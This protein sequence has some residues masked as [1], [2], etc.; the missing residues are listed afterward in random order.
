MSTQNIETRET[1]Y[2]KYC[3]DH[4]ELPEE[5]FNRAIDDLEYNG[6]IVNRKHEDILFIEAT[7]DLKWGD[8]CHIDD[9]IKTNILLY[10]VDN[11]SVFFV[12]YNTQKGKLR[13]SASEMKNWSQNQDFKMVAFMIVDNDK[14]LADQ[15]AG[16]IRAMF[17]ND[18]KIFILSSN[19][20]T[21]FDDI[22]VYIDAYASDNDNEYSMPIIVLLPNVKQIE[23]LLAILYHIDKKVINY[24]S[25]L[26][27][28]I[29]IDE[30]DKTYPMIRNKS[31]KINEKD[32]SIY[33]CIT[34]G[35][36]LYR[37][38]FVTATDGELLENYPECSN[39][40]MFPIEIEE[41]AIKYY[42]AFHTKDAVRNIVETTAYTRTNN[43]YAKDILINNME[44]FK[45]PFLCNGIKIYRKIIINS[46]TKGNDM[47]ALAGYAI[48]EGFYAITFNQSGICV[49]RPN[50]S[51]K[52]TFKIKGM[53]LNELL[54]CIYK[55]MN[56][57]DRPII[58]IGRRKV[59]RGLGF[60]Y[61]PRK[62]PST[63]E[64]NKQVINW[65]GN[66]NYPQC[67]MISDDGEG[68]I[69]T[70]M[71]LGHIEDKS[72]ASQKSGRLAGIISQCPQYTGV[73]T[74]WTDKQTSELILHHNAMVDKSNSLTGYSASQ[75][76]NHAREMVPLPALARDVEKEE[77]I[78]QI[79]KSQSEAR[80]FYNN[81]LKSI[82][83]EKDK[84]KNPDT[85]PKQLR[86]PNTKIPDE[87]GFYKS[88]IRGKED[89]YSCE[90]MYKE[91][92]CNT[93]D[94]GAGYALRPCYRDVNDKTT[95][96]WWFIYAKD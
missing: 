61:A 48:S 6:Y 34:S 86:G 59:D 56:L 31:I 87:R 7:Q 20:K 1:L 49:Y 64:F 8:F 30:A 42:R 80:I 19:T 51:S 43:A 69:W 21:T 94:N 9:P 77:P 22:K 18:G 47:I 32:Y 45:T 78:I 2:D 28:G 26:R 74:F 63:Q 68:L 67:D 10:L 92:R 46:N 54:F 23:K 75:S 36:G 17:D 83:E 60:H 90:E 79:F 4:H 37:V 11:P 71:I 62:D 70:D 72:S 52:E 12:L 58:I 95:L 41:N 55:V 73:L 14:A 40:Y 93:T 81:T 91:R 65:K 84:K 33:H 88:I 96:E 13:I 57:N 89:I 85:K 29:I 5:E 66:S 27:Y 3:Q 50:V 76:V 53:R 44:S 35:C 15:S 16:G 24:T 38:G 39:A 82:L 25:K